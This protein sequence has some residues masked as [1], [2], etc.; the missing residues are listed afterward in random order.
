MKTTVVWKDAMEFEGIADSHTLRMDA[1]APIGKNS[2]PTPKELVALGLGGCTAM[3]VIALLK[4]HKQP[5]QDFKIDIDIEPSTN[6]HPVV[7]EKA[8]LSF[9]V[10][11]EISADKLVEA[12][13]LS[14]TKFC[15]VSAMLSESFPIEYKVI[16]NGKEIGTG[17]AKFETKD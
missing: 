11:G 14:Q 9:I 15:G 4:K 1:K 7:F 5:T 12:V 10:N 17:M 16:L 2:A 13:T 6:G 8:V 3:D